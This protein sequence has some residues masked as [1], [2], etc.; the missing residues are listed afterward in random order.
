MM[1]KITSNPTFEMK[2]WSKDLIALI[3][4]ERYEPPIKG[5]PPTQTHVIVLGP[6][7]VDNLLKVITDYANKK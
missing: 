3:A 7:D 6:E 2:D 5:L 4:T 1:Q